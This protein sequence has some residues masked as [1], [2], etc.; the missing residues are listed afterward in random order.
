MSI[1]KTT[2]FCVQMREP[3]DDGWIISHK[4]HPTFKE[5]EACA[6]EMMSEYPT[7]YAFRITREIITT[8]FT[9]YQPIT[10]PATI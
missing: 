4:T 6:H 7:G 1:T 5:A 9:A 8:S 3:K 10:N 2:K